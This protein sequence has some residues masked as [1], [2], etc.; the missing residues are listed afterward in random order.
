MPFRV[1][2][3]E[4]GDADDGAAELIS[5]TPHI[6]IEKARHKGQA[7]LVKRLLEG[8]RR[9][10]EIV[11]RFER[12]GDVLEKLDHPNVARFV[13][14]EPGV[15]M[16]EYVEGNS[17][18]YHLERGPLEARRAVHVAR[19]L[20]AAIAH[21]HARS[22]IHLDLKPGNILLEPDDKVRVIDFGCAKD[23][24]LEAITHHEARLGTPHYMAP[25]QFRGVRSDARSDLYSAGAVLFETLVGRPPFAPDPFSWLAGRGSPPKVWPRDPLLRAIAERALERDPDLR[26]Q[27]ALEMLEALERLDD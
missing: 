24:T 25:E 6:R 5:S 16:R 22:I 21:A 17:L 12:E 27:T 15:L 2:P 4:R 14:R 13:H 19:G 3:R 26:F 1:T 20:L 18:F 10:P 8:A 23:L 11:E 9:V 7:V